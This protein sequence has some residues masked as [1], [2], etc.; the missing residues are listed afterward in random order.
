MAKSGEK[1]LANDYN[2]IYN[3]LN[4]I[5]EKWS[6]SSL[7]QSIE[8]NTITLSTSM[9]Q[10]QSDLSLTSQES[11]FVQTTSYNLENI[12]I[13][14]INKYATF[15]Y[16]SSIISSFDQACIDYS[17]N[18]SHRS[19]CSNYTN[20][21]SHRS[22]YQSSDYSQGSGTCPSNYSGNYSDNSSHRSVYSGTCSGNNSGDRNVGPY[23]PSN[24]GGN[25]SGYC[26][27]NCS[28]VYNATN[29]YNGNFANYPSNWR[30]HNTPNYSSNRSN[31]SQGGSCNSNYSSHKSS[32]YGHRSSYCSDYSQGPGCISYYS[33]DCSNYSDT[34]YD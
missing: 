4:T 26:S 14:D 27:S 7:N 34:L 28:A 9:L 8:Q 21:S 18:A 29:S 1:V 13:G 6:L 2:Q 25:H 23:C 24:N 19:D 15:D 5:R 33:T 22:S 10:L 20:Y 3:Q 11:K 12:Q 30:A 32:N 16:I 31:Y 17:N